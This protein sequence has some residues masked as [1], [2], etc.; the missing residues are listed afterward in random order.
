[1][2]YYLRPASEFIP[3]DQ[4]W[5][6]DDQTATLLGVTNPERGIGSH[7][8]ANEGESIWDAIRRLAPGWLESE[9]HEPFCKLDLEPG[10][11][12]PRMAR[13]VGRLSAPNLYCPSS[14]LERTTLAVARS[15]LDALS[16]E[17]KRI[18]QTVHPTE[19]TF[20]AFGHDIRN[21]L[22]LA[23]TEVEAHW[24]GI[25]KANGYIKNRCKTT[26]YVKLM[27][28][29]KLADYAI[30]FPTYPWLD[31]IFPFEGWGALGKST[32]ELGWYH[33]Y[34]KVKHDRESEFEYGNL[35]HIF[36]AVSACFIM[37]I[38][39][40]GERGGPFFHITAKPDW[41]ATDFHIRSFQT[42]GWNPVEFPFAGTV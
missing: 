40:F 12:Y 37:M 30:S 8:K 42:A 10:Q 4:I 7:F 39:Q 31:P 26:D 29:M 38:A 9:G 6:I 24:R 3:G 19:S 2:T 41:P 32:Q 35:R 33:A 5:K 17:L 16:Q 22:I 11:Y 13:P 14:Y 36:Q 27:G 21:L 1:M 15:Q 28:A 23:C 25:L 20:N 34:N 18:C